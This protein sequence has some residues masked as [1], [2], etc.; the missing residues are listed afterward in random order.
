MK[1]LAALA[2]LAALADLIAAVVACTNAK[3][4]GKLLRRRTILA[5]PQPMPSHCCESFCEK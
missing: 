2:A 1:N 3:S 5:R 4:S